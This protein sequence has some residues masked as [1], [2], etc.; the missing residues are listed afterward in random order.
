MPPKNKSA[1]AKKPCP[2]CK[3]FEDKLLRNHTVDKCKAIQ[4]D[5]SKLWEDF[6][7]IGEPCEGPDSIDGCQLT[8]KNLLPVDEHTKHA[9]E[10][11][12][13]KAFNAPKLPKQTTAKNTASSAASSQL[14]P[15]TQQLPL[16]PK[17]NASAAP[18][19]PN[20]DEA[21]DAKP[22]KW[23]ATYQHPDGLQRASAVITYEKAVWQQCPVNQISNANT[24]LPGAAGIAT[25]VATNYVAVEKV[26]LKLYEYTVKYVSASQRKDSGEETEV[27][28]KRLS[29]KQRVWE[30]LKTDAVFADRKDWATDLSTVWSLTPLR[31]ARNDHAPSPGQIFMLQDL[32]YRKASGAQATLSK[33]EFAYL[34]ELDLSGD[35]SA[36]SRSLINCDTNAKGASIY[37]TA[38]NGLMSKHVTDLQTNSVTQVGPNKFFLNDGFTSM[39]HPKRGAI[40]PVNAHRGY[41]SSVRPGQRQILLNINAKAGAFFNPMKVS[42]FLKTFTF[43]DETFTSPCKEFDEYGPPTKV[44]IG[45]SVRICYERVQLSDKVNPNDEPNRHKTI[46]SFGKIPSKQTF[47]YGKEDRH[48]TVKHFF[49]KVLQAIVPED[50]DKYPC[51][52]VGLKARYPKVE[53]DGKIV[54]AVHPD[55]VGKEKWIP[56]VF[57]ELDP[58]QPFTYKLSPFHMEKMLEAAQ[59][60]AAETQH[61]IDMEGIQVLGLRQ[62]HGLTSLGLEIVPKLLQIPARFLPSPMIAY[63]NKTL[64]GSDATWSLGGGAQADCKFYKAPPLAKATEQGPAYPLRRAVHVLDYTLAGKGHKSELHFQFTDRLKAH[65]L[66][67]AA[68]A[69]NGTAARGDAAIDQFATDADMVRSVRQKLRGWGNPDLF[70]ILLE[71]KTSGNYDRVKRVFDQHLGLHTV[72]IT[73]QKFQ[74][75]V[76]GKVG[77]HQMVWSNLA[78]KVNSKWKGQNHQLQVHNRSKESIFHGIEQDTIVLGAD[79]AH[80]PNPMANCPSIAAVVGNTDKGFANFPGSM[81]LQASHQEIIEELEA[82]VY[83]RVKAYAKAEGA[84]PKRM[85][86]YR[87][88]VG[89]DQFKIVR[90]QEIRQIYAAFDTVR[91]EMKNRNIQG[92]HDLKLDLTFIVVGKRHNTRFFCRNETQTIRSRTGQ[93]SSTSKIIETKDRRGQTVAQHSDLRNGNPKPGLLVDSVITRPTLANDPTYDFFLQSH[94]ALQGTAKSGHYTVLLPGTLSTTQIQNLTHAFC[95]NY[96]R[97]TKGVSYVGP[98]YYAD[99]LCERGSAYLRAYTAGKEM[100]EWAKS[101]EEVGMGK[102]GMKIYNR[103][104][105]EGIMGTREWCPYGPGR[106]SPWHPRFDDRMFWL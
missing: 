34:R 81:R 75:Q 47:Y 15:P 89:E 5:I 79:V 66:E 39:D 38:L 86:F 12:Y 45:K 32:V 42:T 48:I 13:Q 21:S 57:L 104:V 87:D 72:C 59:H 33:V 3:G 11:M 100:P 56:A 60:H 2:R 40:P 9:L 18:A 85:I 6:E 29:E 20:T 69:G 55:D 97:A 61:L 22:P 52:N 84:L 54:E 83:E 19:K 90:E 58:N 7:E 67:F 105:A 96:A 98:A 10:A 53:R 41:F 71:D 99:R 62:T 94:E 26:P 43:P 49:V 64:N 101:E 102:E 27:E 77:V 91:D 35:K 63:Q 46:A 95:Y 70:L 1:A 36:A 103:R 82:M 93:P 68:V 50:F 30:A 73:A 31:F 37:I 14:S 78:L 24:K 4:P 88:G 92:R 28:V 51:V 23:K 8:L 65:G 44:L 74:R 106:R 80:A 17:T 76:D 25:E 16:Q